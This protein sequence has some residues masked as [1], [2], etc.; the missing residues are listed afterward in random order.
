MRFFKNELKDFCLVA[1]CVPATGSAPRRRDAA[2][3]P[4]LFPMG[5]LCVSLISL[6]P[7]AQHQHGSHLYLLPMLIGITSYSPGP[8]GGGRKR[9]PGEADRHPF[10]L[11]QGFH[12]REQK[13]CR[14]RAPSRSDG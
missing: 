7:N 8:G 10:P 9:R 3:Y 6:K 4:F 12:S 13:S 2:G 11:R 14:N 5:E 1:R